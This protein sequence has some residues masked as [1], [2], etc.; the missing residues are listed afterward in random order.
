LK[1]SSFVLPDGTPSYGRVDGDRLVDCGDALRAALP[2]LMSVIAADALP[3]LNDADGNSFALSEVK[4]LPTIPK[5]D[6][7]ICIGLNYMGHV[8]ETGRDVPAYPTIFTRYP[9]TIVGHGQPLIRSKLSDDFDFEGEFAVVIG[10]PGHHVL[11]DTAMDHVAGYT[12]FNDGSF[13]DYQR[14][15]TQFWGGKNFRQSGSMGPWMVTPDELGDPTAPRMVTRLNTEIMQDTSVVDLAFSITDL[16]VY[17]SS[18]LELSPGDIIATGT[19]SGVGLFR[20]PKVFMKPGDVIEVE[21]EGIGTL[22][23]PVADET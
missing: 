1:I 23:N 4:M 3:R 11:K 5:P 10:K 14:H 21:I 17:L 18:I 8:R 22:S 19:P 7:I 16:I 6:K 2:D 15:T 13:R 9:S 12:C 20:D